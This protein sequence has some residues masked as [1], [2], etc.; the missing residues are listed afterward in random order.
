MRADADSPEVNKL[1][2]SGARWRVR[3]TA[4]GL[5]RIMITA[6]FVSFFV[7]YAI[8]WNIWLG[9]FAL[10]AIL[11]IIYFSSA[12]EKHGNILTKNFTDNLSAREKK[13]L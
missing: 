13:D 11:L 5:L 3:I 12:L 4:Y 7:N 2:E 10:I 9:L 6:V 8:P 1:W